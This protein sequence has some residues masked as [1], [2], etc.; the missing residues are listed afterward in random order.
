MPDSPATFREEPNIF[1]AVVF[2]VYLNQL[3]GWIHLYAYN[4]RPGFPVSL[5]TS[6]S[7]R[8]T[9]NL[10]LTFLNPD[11][12][13]DTTVIVVQ[14]SNTVVTIDLNGFAL[15]GPTFCGLSCTPLGN[16]QGVTSNSGVQFII[17]RNGFIR[18]MGGYGTGFS[19]ALVENVTSEHNGGAAFLVQ[20]GVVRNSFASRNA[21]GIDAPGSFVTGTTSR[22][23]LGLGI[24]AQR[25]DNSEAIAN[26][27]VGFE[28][29]GSVSNSSSFD[30]TGA[31]LACEAICPLSG[32]YFS[33]CSGS[34]CF[35]GAGT[36][37]QVPADS[38]TCGSAIC[39]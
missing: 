20:G 33:G 9:S 11:I 35:G 23:N 1:V 12:A 24:R 29:T 18:G 5:Y 10:D 28:V 19:K 17:L 13:K 4:D 39:P 3:F 26:A 30:N 6:G 36:Y 2:P 8:L 37:L 25:I 22:N 38:N 21:S 32:N 31:E 14:G 15:I 7:Y 16:G 34:G 27:G